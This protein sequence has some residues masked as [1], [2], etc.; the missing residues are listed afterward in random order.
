MDPGIRV[1]IADDGTH[2]RNGLRALLSS[3]P[4]VDVVREASDG[5]EAIRLVEDAQPDVV[6]MDVR[7]PELDG[8]RATRLIKRR[9]PQ[10]RVVVLTL[11]AAYLAE[12]I[13]VGADGFLVKGCPTEDL[14]AAVMSDGQTYPSPASRRTPR[15]GA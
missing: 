9:W 11:Y 2:W 15:N 13:A 6:L 5:Q 3:L 1:L 14:L 8:L 12:A 10:V 7:M 4:A